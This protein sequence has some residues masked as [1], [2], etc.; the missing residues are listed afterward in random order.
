MGC[1]VYALTGVETVKEIHAYFV[2]GSLT[3]RSHYMSDVVEVQE[4]GW[5]KGSPET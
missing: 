4:V 1:E 3:V 5:N 2:R